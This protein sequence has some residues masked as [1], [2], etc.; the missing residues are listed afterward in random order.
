MKKKF[1]KFYFDRL[2]KN[3]KTSLWGMGVGKLIVDF[4][5]MLKRGSKVLDLGCGEGRVALYLAE[6]GH[7][8]TAVDISETGISRLEEHAKKQNLDVKTEV[9][10]LENYKIKENYDCIISLATIHFLTKKRVYSLVREIKSKTI[11]GGF[12]FIT[13]FRKEDPSE[14]DFEMYFFENGELSKMYGDWEIIN[15]REF[16]KEDRHGE[17]GR[18]HYHK[19][20]NLI[21]QKIKLNSGGI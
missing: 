10:D 20:A 4:E 6:K 2:Y 5:K 17:K 7:D 1:D 16:R 18:L 21:A 9:A 13:V 3:S 19:N 15:Y 8:V 12:N 11:K 14:K